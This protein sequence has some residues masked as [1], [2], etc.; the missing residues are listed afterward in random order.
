MDTGSTFALITGGSLGIGKALARECAGRG[1]NLL[2]VALKHDELEIAA[3]EIKEEFSVEVHTLEIDLRRADAPGEVLDW[4]RQHGYRVNVLIN[5]AGMAGTRVFETSP[6]EYSD[7][8]IL[9]NIRAL[10][11]ITRLFLP[12]LRSHPGAYILNTGSVS[13][14]YPIAFK[15]VYAASKAFVLSF[16]RALREELR[17]SN[18][19]VTVVNP[20]GVRTNSDTHG[21]IDSH[22]GIAKRLFIKDV[23]LVARV[24][25]EGMLKGRL[26]VVPGFANRLLLAISGIMPAGLRDRRVAR[27]FRKEL[28]E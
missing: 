3:K 8:R 27:I 24:A 4:C 22:T 23:E 6:L 18:I 7:E 25:V 15:S 13:A 1:M 5:N 26:V 14:Y 10:V 12:E 16:T 28:L 17:G 2:L 21:R 9:V 20:N 11:I 19:S